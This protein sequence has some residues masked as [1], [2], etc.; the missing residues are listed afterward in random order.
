MASFRLKG[1]LQNACNPLA[2]SS[3]QGRKMFPVNIE[4]LA[5]HTGLAPESR[6]SAVAQP[7]VLSTTYER[8]SE[9]DYPSG[10]VYSRLANPNRHALEQCLCALEGGSDAAAFASGSAATTAIIQAL[11]PGDHV[12]FPTEAYYG[13]AAVVREVGLPW[14]IHASFCDMT[15]TAELAAT[16]RPDTRLIWIETPSNPA[17]RITDIAACGRIARQAGAL[18]VCDNT[19]PTPVLTRPLEHGA[20]F[21]VHSSSKYLGGHGDVIGGAVVAGSTDAARK[22]F[23]RIRKLQT[24]AG[25]VPSP[26][27]SW[28]LHRGLATLSVR[29]RAQ[30]ESAAQIAKYLVTHP[31]VESVHYPGLATAAGHETAARQMSAFGAMLSFQVRGDRHT[32]LAV[33]GRTRL[34]IQATSLGSVESLI[35][36]RASV[37]NYSTPTPENLLRVSVGL[38]HRDDLM[39]DL[40]KAL[41]TAV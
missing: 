4:T 20:D 40:A 27:D 28:L 21:V 38:E 33:A 2:I 9:G 10:Y 11:S 19:W 13:T 7:I 14:G 34:F 3:L 5:I 22:A 24:T 25:A 37:E 26:F 29:V 8:S 12:I 30:S 18:L 1:S 36:H 17:L 23:Q 39:E 41:E 6:G 31:A 16:V 32:A 15:D 35:E